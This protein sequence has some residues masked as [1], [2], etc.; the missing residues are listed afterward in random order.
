MG[1]K[2]CRNYKPVTIYLEPKHRD[3]ATGDTPESWCCVDCGF[4]THPG[5]PGR[6]AILKA[7]D[8]GATRIPITISDKTE[9]YVVKDSIWER[10]GNPSGC[11]CVGCLEKR[12]GRRLK[13]KDFP[14]AEPLNWFPASPRLASRMK[15]GAPR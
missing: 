7:F 2:V 5:S 9:V 1:T 11:L 13:P 4:D 8:E 12:L 10:A 6:A 14:P 3:E 15:R